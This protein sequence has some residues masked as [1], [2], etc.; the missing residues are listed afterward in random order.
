MIKFLKYCLMLQFFIQ[1]DGNCTQFSQDEE[2]VES[3][4]LKVLTFI[5]PRTIAS[6]L[7]L[8]GEKEYEALIQTYTDVLNYQGIDCKVFPTDNKSKLKSSH[9]L[10]VGDMY[11]TSCTTDVDESFIVSPYLVNCVGVIVKNEKH[12]FVAHLHALSAEKTLKEF[13]EDITRKYN[14][15]PANSKVSI[16]TS[17]RSDTL[18]AA[19]Q[20]FKSK[21]YKQMEISTGPF[22]MSANQVFVP[23]FFF[24]CEK[25]EAIPDLVKSFISCAMIV[26]TTTGDLFRLNSQK[27]WEDSN[28]ILLLKGMNPEDIF[29]NP[30]STK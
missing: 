6:N 29:Y 28:T 4:S 15:M 8:V 21:G 26:S 10:N 11:V 20:L 9:L 16:L 13:F 17:I 27:P 24:Q 3:N 2:K 14:F 5:D 1:A 18:S 19:I 23:L 25:K 22:C 12:I 7:K 30:R